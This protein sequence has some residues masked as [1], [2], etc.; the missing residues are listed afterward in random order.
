MLPFICKIQSKKF[1]KLNKELYK[2]SA[3][4]QA[5]AEFKDCILSMRSKAGYHLVELNIGKRKDYFAFLN[6]LI[7][8]RKNK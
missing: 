3:L 1:I 5:A 6:Y 2:K 7:Y 4:N 8:L